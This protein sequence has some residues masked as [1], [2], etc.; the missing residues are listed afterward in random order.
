VD[1][2]NFSKKY[3][4]DFFAFERGMTFSE[5][6]VTIGIFSIIMIGVNQLFLKSWQNYNLV[7]HTN[8][9]SIAANRGSS[10]IVNV[11]RRLGAGD[12]G[13]YPI[14][15]VGSF[16]LKIYSDIDNDGVTEKV[17]YYLSGTNLMVGKSNPS[18]F[19]LTYPA[20]DSEAA[21]LIKNVVNS[22]AQP[23]FYYYDGDN[24]TMG[25]P[26]S[27]LNNIRMIEVNLFIDRKEGDLN[28]ESYASLRNLSEHDTIE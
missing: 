17:H 7:M 5:V 6:I 18:G 26:S 10:E 22:A 16:D 8:E 1:K 3:K 15:S 13:S 23:L 14:L 9:A 24:N 4:K 28:I 21:I 27:N 11:L 2:F 19:P 12:D 20:L 25:S